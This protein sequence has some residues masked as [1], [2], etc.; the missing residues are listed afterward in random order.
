MTKPTSCVCRDGPGGPFDCRQ[1]EHVR[2]HQQV[3]S[4]GRADHNE[5]VSAV[6][7]SLALGAPCAFTAASYD[8]ATPHPRP[9]TPPSPPPTTHP[10]GHPTRPSLPTPVL[11]FMGSKSGSKA[12]AALFHAAAPVNAPIFHRQPSPKP[13]GAGGAPG[14][15][16]GQAA[17]TR[18]SCANSS[19]GG[20]GSYSG[21]HVLLH[22]SS[23][24]PLRP[25]NRPLPGGKALISC[26]QTGRSGSMRTGILQADACDCYS[27]HLHVGHSSLDQRST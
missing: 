21:T 24:R 11:V 17:S 13:A 23:W 12:A 1:G 6:L 16:A 8:L 14:K 27:R 15:R 9:P 26:R 10:L 4:C 5:E 22:C 19:W 18:F 25:G 7:G 20:G 3:D 2:I